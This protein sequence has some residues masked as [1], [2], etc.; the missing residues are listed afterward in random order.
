MQQPISVLCLLSAAT[1]FIGLGGDSKEDGQM[2]ETFFREVGRPPSGS[3]D[4]VFVHHVGY[5]SQYR[6]GGEYSRWPLPRTDSAADIAVFAH[7]RNVA[8]EEPELGDL[9]LITD[10]GRD[11]ILRVGIVVVLRR[12]QACRDWSAVTTIEGNVGPSDRGGRS[13][14]G[15]VNRELYPSRGDLF[16]RWPELDARSSLKQRRPAQSTRLTRYTRRVV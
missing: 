3:W 16:V 4:T 6:T 11:C 14:V 8:Y 10:A 9:A 13:V 15:R 1:A 12:E 5:W 7:E 2:V